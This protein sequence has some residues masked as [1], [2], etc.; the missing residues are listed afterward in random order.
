LKPADLLLLSPFFY[1]DAITTGKYNTVLVR[2]L[3]DRGQ[4]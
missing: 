4:W 3:V 2:A 1:P